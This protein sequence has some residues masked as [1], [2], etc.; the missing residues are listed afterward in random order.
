MPINAPKITGGA[1]RSVTVDEGQI[2]VLNSIGASDADG[3][4][5][6]YKIVGGLDKS[7]FKIDANGKLTFIGAQDFEK[8]LDSNKDGTYQVIVQVADGPLSS[9]T[10]LKT[11]QTITV[12]LADV[13]AVTLDGSSSGESLGGVDATTEGDTLN[14]LGG[15]DT[16]DGGAGADTMDGGD[17]DDTFI[18]DDIGDVVVEADGLDGGIDTVLSSVNYTI[19]DADVENL[20]LT[21]LAL[22]ATGNASDNVLTGNAKNNT[23]DGLGGNDTMAG[24]LGSDIY[25]VDS[26][27]DV[28]TEAAS[29]GTDKVIASANFTLGANVENLTLFTNKADPGLDLALSG[30]GNALGNSIVGNAAANTLDGGAGNDKINGG[31]GIDDMTGGAG[32]DAFYVDDTDDVVHENATEGTDTVFASATYTLSDN[33][34]NLTLQGK[35]DIDGT[36]NALNNKITG[37]NGSNL[38]VGLGGNDTLNG[39]KGADT[40]EGGDGSDTYYVNVAGD[41]VTEAA[42][43]SGD[44]D[45]IIASVNYTA[46]ANVE[47][48]TLAGAAV[49][50]VGNEL[51]NYIKGTTAANILSGGAGDDTLDGGSGDDDMTGGDGSDTF[52]VTSVDDA[53]HE[54]AG[55]SGDIDT[56]KSTVSYTLGENL[57]NLTLTGFGANSGAGNSLDN[58]IIGN[59]AA[60]ALTGGGG[61]DWLDGGSGNDTMNGGNGSD[62]YVVAQTGDVVSDSGSTGTDTVR[63]AVSFTLDASLENL[64]ITG[65]GTISATGNDSD[66]VIIGGNGANVILGKGGMDTMTGGTGNDTFRFDAITDSGT[67]V[68]VDTDTITD[69]VLGDKIDLSRID[70]RSDADFQHF[71]LSTD[72]IGSNGEIVMTRSGN[73]ITVELHTN[74]DAVADMK[75]VVH[76]NES[77]TGELLLGSFIL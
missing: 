2:T 66:N 64:T 5:L 74:N 45:T 35:L 33:V 31:A 25:I 26:S 56:V 28:V 42:G 47:N 44:V 32:N 51:D 24:G 67:D 16:L 50:G 1:T 18:V 30:T 11:L 40:M 12:T 29:S 10:T 75:F 62:T 9:G 41:V 34:E 68:G 19:T 13:E 73:D 71:I 69:F 49:E 4:T 15:N 53:V 57:E 39:G 22:K 76:V 59:S 27:D 6:N 36:G 17:G 48:L 46:S 37:N 7:K 63:S 60:N 8:P 21:G 70:A 65:T 55:L 38:L 23:I 52:I 14:G 72:D 61:D 20:T 3:D 54:G 58:T 77:I 43:V